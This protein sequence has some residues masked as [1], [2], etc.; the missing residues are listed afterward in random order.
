MVRLN[1]QPEEWWAAGGPNKFIER[2]SDSL[3]IP[4]SKIKVNS[5]FGGST[6]VYYAIE[7]ETDQELAEIKEK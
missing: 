3:D 6:I 2:V 7:G 5:V 4:A 1:M